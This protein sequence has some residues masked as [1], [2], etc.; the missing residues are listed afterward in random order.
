M[1]SFTGGPGSSSSLREANSARIIDTIKKYG[2][3]TQVE[4]AAATNLSPA[5]VSNIVKQLS[6][7]RIVNTDT[8]I[9]SGRRA[10]LVSMAVSNGLAIGVQIGKR[11]LRLEL[12]DDAHRV[13]A[14]HRLPLPAKHRADTTLDRTALLVMDLLEEVGADA[15]DL[16]AIGVTLPAPVDPE[17]GLISGPSHLDLWNDVPVAQ[18]LESR[19]GAPVVVENDANA[20][21]LGEAR[22]GALR[23]IDDGIYVHAS[24]SIGAGLLLGGS[25]HHGRRGLAGEIGHLQIDPNGLV[26]KCGARGCLE[27]LVGIDAILSQLRLTRE[28]HSLA[29]LISAANTGDAGCRRLISDAAAIIG[30]ALADLAT[31]FAPT[32]IIIGGD[33]TQTGELFLSPIREALHSG[34]GVLEGVDVLASPLDGRAEVL[35]ALALARDAADT[36]IGAHT[37][38]GHS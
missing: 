32:R 17:T 12:A 18:V 27:T 7:Q 15:E 4:L 19:L 36:S 3:I 14:R 16:L 22:F 37:L 5:T 20:G 2:H 30:R 25:I 11:D 38:R 26:C 10:Q 29:D 1:R 28:A 13:T 6:A 21:A 31:A 35:G 9:R 8:T 24:R 23:N 33:Y 34:P